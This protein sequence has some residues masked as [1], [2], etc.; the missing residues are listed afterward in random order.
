MDIRCIPCSL[1]NNNSWIRNMTLELTRSI[2]PD[3]AV[4]QK[5]LAQRDNTMGPVGSRSIDD[6][7]R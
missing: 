2:Y 3:F 1:F 7:A 6:T 5:T 4:S